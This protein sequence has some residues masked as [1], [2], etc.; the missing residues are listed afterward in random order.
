MA[1][2]APPSCRF[3]SLYGELARFVLRLLG[4]KTKD[5]QQAQQQQQ[6]GGPQG[7]AQQQ[8][9]PS[10]GRPAVKPHGLPGM[11]AARAPAGAG[12]GG[13]Q[14]DTLWQKDQ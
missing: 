3:G 5:K 2:A 11:P 13:G 12:S 4:F 9:G 8:P 7:A 10:P 6:P 1:P 14:W